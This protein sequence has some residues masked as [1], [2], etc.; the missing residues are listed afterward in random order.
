ME[1][2]KHQGIIYGKLQDHLFQWDSAWETFRPVH[3][4]VWDGRFI[5]IPKYTSDIF[6]PNYGFGSPEMKQL[7]RRLTETTELDSAEE[8]IPWVAGEWF[9]DR[10]VPFH[11]CVPRT[12]QGW[13][14]YISYTGGSQ[15]T[16][17][18]QRLHATK[19]LMPK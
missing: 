5:S 9:K 13:K 1:L 16:L 18:R 3:E 11:P 6:D 7:C 2:R 4:I 8:K 17:R 15:K 14:N 12:V 10:L 19:R